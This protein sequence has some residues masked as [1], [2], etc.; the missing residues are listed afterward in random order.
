MR[1][2]FFL[3][4]ALCGLSLLTPLKPYRPA[5]IDE[6]G[7]KRART[8]LAENDILLPMGW[9]WQRYD[10][11]E[12]EMRWG[13][14][15]AE[16]DRGTLIFVPGYSNYIEAYGA[17]LS[18]WHEAGF[19][20]IAVDLPGQGGSTRRAD[21]PEK[22]IGGDYS[23]YAEQLGGFIAARKAEANSPVTLVAES[24][25][26]HVSLRG[27]A[28]GTIKADRTAL[29]V[30]GLSL[31][32][33]GLPKSFI[34]GMIGRLT[35]IGYGSRYAPTQGAWQPKWDTPLDNYGCATRPDRIY[36]KDA[37]FSLH[38]EFRIG[39]I[40]NEWAA[41]FERS[42][43]DLAEGDALTRVDTDILMITAGKD[44]ILDY[45]RTYKVCDELLP[46]CR[47]IELP[48]AGHCL[49]LEED[50]IT[51]PMIEAVIEFASA[52]PRSAMAR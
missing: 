36:H 45:A 9:G 26:A 3:V 51:A 30:P 28:D 31:Q 34:K 14:A 48:E 52:S 41:G 8:Y 33:P 29:L 40:T 23:W 38:P 19:T 42:G 39:G 25:G 2:S 43:R 7:M 47:R 49:L 17:F 1:A 5:P 6:A 32:T 13:M 44:K 4:T 27:L 15:R 10:F 50:A 24:F 12:G 11:G 20:V 37:I 16:A 22:P 35:D 18:D 21:F 46:H